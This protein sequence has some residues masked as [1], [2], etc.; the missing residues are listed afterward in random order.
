M[1]E[2]TVEA[3]TVMAGSARTAR[4]AARAITLSH[5]NCPPCRGIDLDQ[6]RE[7]DVAA[8]QV[9]TAFGLS[10]EARR[11]MIKRACLSATFR[12]RGPSMT[13]TLSWTRTASSPRD[14]KYHDHGKRNEARALL[15]P[16][17]GWFT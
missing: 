6:D 5:H 12:R 8:L 16:V 11:A 4:P 3:L 17:Y 10:P 15:A 14:A 7:A 9:G 1:E 13:Q 2:R